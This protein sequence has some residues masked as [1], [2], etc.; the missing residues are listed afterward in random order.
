MALL[1]KPDK[2]ENEKAL[3]PDQAAAKKKGTVNKLKTKTDSKKVVPTKQSKIAPFTRISSYFRGVA[4]E[5]KKV[6][7][8]TRREV[9]IYTGVVVVAVV[10]VCALIWVF[11]LAM[12]RLMQ[13]FI[14]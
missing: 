13:F 5:L 10:I 6:H 12:G 8:P 1:K 3:A 11:D 2:D 4:G 14:Q 7:W 9:L